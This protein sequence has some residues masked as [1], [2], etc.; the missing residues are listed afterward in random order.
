[1]DAKTRNRFEARARIIKAM[2]HGTRLFIVEEL[3]RQER[4]VYELTDMIDRFSYR[5]L[6]KDCLDLPEKVYTARFVEMTKEQKDMYESIRK[7]ALV[8]LDDGEMTTAAA[9]RSN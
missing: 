7:H 4:C 1:M 2:A 5:V 9:S 8:M 6:K 3:S